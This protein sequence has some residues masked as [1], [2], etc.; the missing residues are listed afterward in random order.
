MP[1]SIYPA[2][3]YLFRAFLLNLTIHSW[4]QH[5]NLD[6]DKYRLISLL[7]F[8][9]H[10]L[11]PQ[12]ILHYDLEL[13]SNYFCNILH[14]GGTR[15][16]NWLRHCPTSRKVAGLIREGF[17]GIFP[18]TWPFRPYCGPGVDSSEYQEHFFWEVTAVSAYGWQP[19]HHYVPSVL[20]SVT[21][22]LLEPSEPL[23]TC[24][25]TALPL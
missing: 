23:Q 12:A 13:L 8:W 19:Y 10:L 2:W 15:W 4:N 20:K 3:H 22:N 17:I 6:T 1:H 11:D 7:R 21:V 14:F 25:G 16:R 24:I 9:R 18:R 5:C